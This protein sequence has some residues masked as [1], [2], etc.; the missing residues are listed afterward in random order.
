MMQTFTKHEIAWIQ[1]AAA[2][3]AEFYAEHSRSASG[4]EASFASLRSEQMTAIADK[5]GKA[6]EAGNKRIEIKY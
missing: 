4:M 5:L 1:E 2:K 6:L 3:L